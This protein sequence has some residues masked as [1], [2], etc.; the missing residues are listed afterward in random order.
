MPFEEKRR[1]LDDLAE[2][3]VDQGYKVGDRQKGEANEIRKK[4][5][6]VL[7]ISRD[8][9]LRYL[10]DIYTQEV[11]RPS[12]QPT[13][14]PPEKSVLEEAREVLGEAK[15]QQLE[16]EIIERIAEQEY[17]PPIRHEPDIEKQREIKETGKELS[18]GVR[19][20]LFKMQE[21]IEATKPKRE[22]FSNL[23]TMQNI[24][25]QLQS[26][27]LYNPFTPDAYLIWSDGRTLD[28]TIREMEKIVE[29]E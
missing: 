19:R 11:L 22:A 29:R 17:R 12:T 9:V 16:M 20:A 1:W 8:T 5:E 27:L 25:T 3:Y 23:V 26:G 14:T 13:I 10:S 6:E 21:D 24:K 7:G 18:K 15:A 4:L 28:E 2:Y